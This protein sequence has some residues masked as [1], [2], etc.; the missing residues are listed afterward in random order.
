M[1][2]VLIALVPWWG[3]CNEY[4]KTVFFC[5]SAKIML[6][7]YSLPLPWQGTSNEYYN[8]YFCG[9]I[10]K[11]NGWNIF[12]TM[13]NS[14]RSRGKWGWLRHH[15]TCLYNIDPLKPHFY[16]V[17]LGFTEVYIIF[18]ISAQNIDCGYS[19]ELP[20]RS[21][22]NEYPQ[23]MFWPQVWEIF[24]FLSDNFHSLVVKMFSIFE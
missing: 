10:T 11:I 15:E 6:W 2:L 14:A 22:S 12:G 21:S 13:V 4:P 1:L 8:T 20:R 3:S 7:I 19:L 17:K 5:V 16:I 18:L 24:E 9:Q 23:S